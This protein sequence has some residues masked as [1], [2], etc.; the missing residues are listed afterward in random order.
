MI[1]IFNLKKLHRIFFSVPTSM[2]EVRGLDFCFA[3]SFRSSSLRKIGFAFKEEL[4][5]V[6]AF[7]RRRHRRQRILIFK[8]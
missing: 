3:K 2:A 1:L 7:L 5:K 6:L 4:E 8:F